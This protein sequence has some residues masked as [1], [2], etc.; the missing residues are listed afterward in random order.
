MNVWQETALPLWKILFCL[1]ECKYYRMRTDHS[2]IG[3]WKLVG[4]AN[5]IGFGE[6]TFG[7][8]LPYHFERFSSVIE[9]DG[10]IGCKLRIQWLAKENYMVWKILFCHW[11]CWYHRMQTTHSMIGRRKLSGFANPII[12][13][14][15]S[16]GRKLPYHYEKFSSVIESAT[17]IGCELFIQWLANENLI[18]FVNS[19]LVLTNAR[20]NWIFGWS[21]RTNVRLSLNFRLMINVAEIVHFFTIAK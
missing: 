1:W 2:M 3:K 20:G 6:W 13:G 11:E 17:I 10:V 18:D 12:F 8:R 4:F 14:K 5:P 19:L 16:C 21:F 15:W 9:D 7:R